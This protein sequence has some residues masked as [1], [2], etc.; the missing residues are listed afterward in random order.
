ML[1][2]VKDAKQWAEE[3]AAQLDSDRLNSDDKYVQMFN[4]T[5]PTK[6]KELWDSGCW[7]A[8]Q[9]RACGADD[10]QVSAIQMAQGQRAFGGD[11]WQAAVD[12]ANEFEATGDTVEKGGAALA[13]KRH[14]E[15]F[16]RSI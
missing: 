5:M 11:A 14:R 4:R 13:H 8:E 9:L 7:L 10:E 3:N 15:L 6:S 12:Y 1:K 2:T 16:G